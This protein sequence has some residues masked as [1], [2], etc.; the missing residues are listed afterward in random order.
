MTFGA[1]ASAGVGEL[2][3]KSTQCPGSARSDW[4][5][6]RGSCIGVYNQREE[7]RC[8]SAP[9]LEVYCMTSAWVGGGASVLSSRS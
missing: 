9:S 3:I 4:V 6:V 1:Q 5:R 7:G 8:A 2:E